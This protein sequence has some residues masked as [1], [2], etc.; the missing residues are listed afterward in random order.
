M[1]GVADLTLP[2]EPV[3]RRPAGQAVSSAPRPLRF[4]PA[5]PG[6][7]WMIRLDTEQEQ[8]YAVRYDA[9]LIHACQALVRLASEAGM[10][11]IGLL[12]A[13]EEVD[14]HE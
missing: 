12:E 4:V 3:A 1:T 6:V 7:L 8:G 10:T 14:H 11:L 5:G 13:L 9:A 2:A